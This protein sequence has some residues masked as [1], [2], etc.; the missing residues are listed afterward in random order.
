MLD[1]CAGCAAVRVLGAPSPGGA[2][3]MPFSERS[4]S[5]ELWKAI[6]RDT[7]FHKIYH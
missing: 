2:S 4:N 5:S 7:I 1:C 3:E 6:F